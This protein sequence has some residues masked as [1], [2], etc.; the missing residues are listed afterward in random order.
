MMCCEQCGRPLD[1]HALYCGG[2]GVCVVKA[3]KRLLA[4]WR[5]AAA[6]VTLAAVAVMQW[7]IL[8]PWLTITLPDDGTV[9]AASLYDMKEL[10]DGVANIIGGIDE[11]DTTVNVTRAAV[12][13]VQ[14]GVIAAAV[15]GVLAPFVKQPRMVLVGMIGEA[16]SAVTSAAVLWKLYDTL[17]MIKSTAVQ[18]AVDMTAVPFALIAATVIALVCAIVWHAVTARY[19]AVTTE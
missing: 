18:E 4:A 16:V 5:I 7:C 14:A 1:K 6:M 17:D 15:F 3:D 12:W 10:A 8:S 13:T 2:C 19:R 11:L 9:I